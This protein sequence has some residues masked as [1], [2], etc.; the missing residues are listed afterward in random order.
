MSGLGVSDDAFFRLQEA[1]IQRMAQMLIN[2][3]Q[4]AVALK[5]V[6]TANQLSLTQVLRKYCQ[7]NT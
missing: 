2:E 4:A 6:N 1:M 7:I 3:E 5:Q